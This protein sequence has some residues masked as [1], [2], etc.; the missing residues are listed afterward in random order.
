[1]TLTAILVALVVCFVAW[2]LLTGL[3]KFGVI[4]L[5]AIVG[6]YLLYNGMDFGGGVL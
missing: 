6:G 3:I 5:V 2:K 4:V 1:M